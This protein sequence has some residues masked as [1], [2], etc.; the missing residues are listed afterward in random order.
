MRPDELLDRI[1]ES[2]E[3]RVVIRLY[4]HLS[5]VSEA[6]FR[7]VQSAYYAEPSVA[8]ELIAHWRAF[9]DLGDDPSFAYRAKGIGENVRCAAS[10]ALPEIQSASKAAEPV[11]SVN[12]SAPWPTLSQR[13][14]NRVGPISGVPRGVAGRR[15]AH[16]STM[17]HRPTS[18]SKPAA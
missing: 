15:P 6:Y 17:S 13:L 5:G 16:W 8:A 11:A 18:G 1:A 10:P 4:P 3:A 7:R 2:G 14:R 9:R 12:P